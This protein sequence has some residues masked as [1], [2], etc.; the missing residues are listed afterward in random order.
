MLRALYLVP[1][2]TLLP[3]ALRADSWMPPA[4]H[5]FLS[6]NSG[7]VVRVDP[8]S[9][10]T[11]GSTAKTARCRFFRYSEEKKT[12]EFWREHDLV[13]DT[14]PCD[15]LTPNDGSFLVT[16]DDYF[17]M[18]TS[19]NTVVVYDSSGRMLKKWALDDILSDV[20]IRELPASVSSIHWRSDVGVM[21][22]S[23]HEVYISPPKSPFKGAEDKNFKG[24][25]LDVKA[26]TIRE[27]SYENK[28]AVG[29]LD[30]DQRT[31]R[32]WRSIAIIEAVTI[33]AGGAGWALNS[34]RR[35]RRHS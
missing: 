24:F 4:P 3:V 33:I 19:A 7:I 17:G 22:G 26:L 34:R 15:V 28:E 13:N 32:V 12:Y 8:G 21:M 14:L 10:N 9:M 16:F 35:T 29:A 20:E 30:S 2:A 11:D 6:D 18:G 25:M 31:V 5:A 1:F 23:Q 27:R